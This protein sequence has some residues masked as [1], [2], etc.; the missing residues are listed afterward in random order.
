MELECDHVFYVN[1]DNVQLAVGL[2]RSV[3]NWDPP[4]EKGKSKLSRR[5]A[6]LTRHLNVAESLLKSRGSRRKLRELTSKIEDALR[7]LEQASE[8]Y[9]TF[10]ELEGLLEHLKDTEHATER[11]TSY[12]E[13][14]EIALSKRENEPLSEAGSEYGPTIPFEMASGHSSSSRTSE[15][16]RHVQVV[17]LKVEQAKR[18]AQRRQEEE[19]KRAEIQEGEKRLKEQRHIREL[20]YEEERLRPT[21]ELRCRNCPIR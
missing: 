3:N 11:V 21:L 9:Q 5:K 4:R 12:L 20:E 6:T 14:I 1:E 8:E 13:N 18:E 17:S 15:V 19:R 7:E 10:L 2:S 16:K